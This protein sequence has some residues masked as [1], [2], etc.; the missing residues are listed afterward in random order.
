MWAFASLSDQSTNVTECWKGN[1]FEDK[2]LLSEKYG[3]YVLLSCG[4]VL[5][6]TVPRAVRKEVWVGR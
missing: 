4:V 2:R 1:A 5:S 6:L 3:C